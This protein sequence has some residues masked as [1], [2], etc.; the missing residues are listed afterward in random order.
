[1]NQ[2]VGWA[3]APIG[4]LC[5]LNNGRAFKPTEWSDNGLPIVRIQNL[6]DPEAKFNRFSGEFGDRYH[7]KGGELLFAWSGTPGT[8]FGAHVWRGTEALL[9]QHIFRVDFDES[10]VDKRFFRYAI[11]QKLEELIGKAHGGVG[12][13]HVTKGKFEQ[14]EIALPPRA[15]QTR[16]ASEIDSLLSQVNT[17]RERLDRVPQILKKFRE[18]VL[19]AAVSGRL[20]EEWRG[21][22]DNHWARQKLGDV[23]VELRNGLS[24]KP[25][26]VP[27]GVPILRISS[28]RPFSVSEAEIRYLRTDLKTQS[29]E[30][31]PKDLLFTRY[32]GTMEYVGVC[33]MVHS[34]GSKGLVYPD[35]L[36]RVRVNTD[37]VLP[38]W[39]EIVA[40]SPAARV[41]IEGVARTSAGQTGISGGDVK[42]LLVPVPSIDEQRAI[43]RRV[44]ELLALADTLSRRFQEATARVERLTPSILAKAFRGELV[45]QDPDDEPAGEMLE[46]VQAERQSTSTSSRKA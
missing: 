45:P 3:Y 10:V 37:L 25:E 4:D 9:N 2:P 5:S 11:N 22:R 12:L 29:Y 42:A 35:K 40:N 19:E 1:V 24:P 38:E 13:R 26:L 46:R 34:I 17:C 28:V 43:G 36:M 44:V 14:T 20:T 39:I 16:I 41:V 8:S 33:G 23:I 15:E 6:N 21:G 18:A 31:R 7:L 32:S 30:L 27:P